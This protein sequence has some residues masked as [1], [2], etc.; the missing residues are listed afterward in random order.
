MRLG[1]LGAAHTV[2]GSC[3]LLETKEKHYLIDCGMFQGAR[4]VRDLN[5]EGFSFNPADIEG[6]LL[7]HAH[8]DHCGLIPK[9]VREGF[10]GS[11]Y[12]TK[13]TCDL[14]QIMLPDSAHIQEADA[15]M[16]N[17]K[18]RRRGENPVQPIY[19][20]KD[21]AAA[22]EHFVPVPYEQEFE[23]GDN[24]RV[25]FHDAGH[26]LGSAIIELYV[27][28]ENKTTK[29]VF[30][31]DLGQP[32]QPIIRDPAILHGA[33][34]L[35]VE[36]TYGDR[37]HQIYDK[38]S[39]LLEIINDT[40]DRGGNLIIPSFAVGRTQTLLYYLYKLWKAGRLDGDI[41]IVIDSPLA[42]N[43]TRVFLKN[44]Q[45]FDDETID[46][47][48]ESGKITR[49]PQL[50]VCETAEESRALNSS[51][52]SAIIMSASGMADAGRILHHLKHNLWRPESTILFVGYQAEG[53][54][55]R[56]LVDG[57]KRVRVLGE[58]VAVKAK[59]Q[60]LD[61]FSAHADANQLMEWI[62]HFQDP[63]PA[64]V[65]IVHGEG[66]SQEAL[67]SRIQKE[68]GE[69]VYIPF[70]GDVVKIDG[71]ASEIQPSNIPEVS[72]EMEM[73]EQLRFF[74]SEYR[75]LRRKAMQLVIRQP[76]AM[77]PLLKAITK[78]F[79]YMKKLFAP[80]NL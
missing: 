48:K 21:A 12:A 41:P 30:S 17:R 14:V 70:R 53:S 55:G 69:E 80:F 56:R 45:D 3:Y 18:S 44:F 58:E 20:L 47:F 25:V 37:L 13:A 75:T 27:T 64:K 72:V 54:L 5:Y 24:L 8:V 77:E 1:F 33:D 2:T 49:F 67:K 60:M 50:R 28:E 15:E 74:D 61:G 71:R 66:Q 52:G 36:S 11:V 34:F 68:C 22:L 59:I 42:I 46:L 10:Q 7:T 78:G 35:V 38:E 9:L 4:R 6:V 76:K 73:E 32:D 29:L 51:E 26:I 63:K 57:I 16:S 39:A 62:D 43:A 19:T 23:L 31:G 65:F 79:N 40:M